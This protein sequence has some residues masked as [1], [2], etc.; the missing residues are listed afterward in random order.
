MILIGVAAAM[1]QGVGK[2]RDWRGLRPMHSNCDDVKRVLGVTTCKPPDGEYDMGTER[3]KIV[4]SSVKCDRAWQKNWNVPTGT[5]LSIERHFR[6]PIPLSEFDVDLSK[7]GRI[8]TD[9]D[10]LI[11]SGAEEG[12]E[13]WVV[14]NEIRDL[15]YEPIPSDKTLLCICPP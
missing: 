9:S 10:L 1:G 14:G 3:V 5:V 7:F 11:Y 2:P 12:I 6:K 15:Y 13:M 4:F 8:S